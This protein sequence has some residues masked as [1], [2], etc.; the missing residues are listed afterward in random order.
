MDLKAWEHKGAKP[1]KVAAEAE[2]Q[3]LGGGKKPSGATGFRA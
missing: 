1:P 2:E 3:E